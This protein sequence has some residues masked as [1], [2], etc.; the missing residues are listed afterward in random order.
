MPRKA[1]KR[2]HPMPPLSVA[3]KLIYGT[4]FVL[5]VG[6]YI[7]LVL[8]P[9]ILRQKIAFSDAS[10]IASEDNASTFWLIVPWMTFFLMT[11]ILWYDKY[12]SRIPI[13]GRKNFKYGP[14]AWPKVYPLFMKNKPYV[15]VSEKKK[16]QKKQLAVILVIVLAVSFI[17]FPWS[18]YGRDCLRYDGSIVCYNMFNKQTR[19]FASGDIADIEIETFKYGTGKYNTNIHW[20]VQ[21]AFRT[22]SGRKYTFEHREFRTDTG[23]AYSWLD[24]ML[25]LK[26]RFDPGIIH[27]DGQ[28]KLDRVI[29]DWEFSPE[30]IE[31]LYQLFGMQDQTEKN[32]ITGN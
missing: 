24:A 21:I 19:E 30:E 3:D 20:G 8:F 28:E 11:F 17:P 25:R 10:V 27:Y 7:V 32:S 15:W 4:I 26:G 22:D 2:V 6:A 29:A 9:L 18:L 31:K 23:T 5:L 13:F 14:P 12:A 16:R 1:K